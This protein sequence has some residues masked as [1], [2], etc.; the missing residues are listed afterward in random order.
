MSDLKHTLALMLSD[1][2][3]ERFVAEYAQLRIRLDKLGNMISD[4]YS[5]K[6]DFK[7]DC[8]VWFWEKQFEAMHEYACWLEAR[9]SIEHIDLTPALNILDI[10]HEITLQV[11]NDDDGFIDPALCPESACDK[12]DDTNCSFQPDYC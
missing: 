12:C 3:K 11:E 6:L 10:G 2:Y 9:A 5:N 4:A 8:P 1:D 7:P